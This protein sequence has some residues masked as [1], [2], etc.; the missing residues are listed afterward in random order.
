[1]SAS[2]SFLGKAFQFLRAVVRQDVEHFLHVLQDPLLIGRRQSQAIVA[3]LAA[4]SG[5]IR[6][7][8]QPPG[9]RHGVGQRSGRQRL[10]LAQGGGGL[11]HLLFQP[12]LAAGQF[13]LMLRQDLQVGQFLRRE[14]FQVAANR[15][16]AQGGRVASRLF[17]VAEKLDHLA[18]EAA[19]VVPLTQPGQAGLQ[20]RDD[21]LLVL[22]RADKVR[23][24]FR[25]AAGR[26]GRGLQA[27]LRI[28]DGGGQLRADRW[29]MFALQSIELGQKGFQAAAEIGV[30]DAIALQVGQQA[31]HEHGQAIVAAG[32]APHDLALAELRGLQT[33]DVGLLQPRGLVEANLQAADLAAGIALELAARGS[34]RPGSGPAARPSVPATGPP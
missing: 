27:D 7:N 16:R 11:L 22:A 32:Q 9:F 31:K 3:D 28:F 18:V 34:T 26:P 6:G 2:P 5:H 19:V 24:A 15:L 23:F 29:Q 17:L 14:L 21:L 33:I 30:V 25:V 1:M 13:E 20:R 4:R 12:C 10:V 8:R